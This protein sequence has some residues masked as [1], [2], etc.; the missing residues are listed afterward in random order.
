MST[1]HNAKPVDNT[2]VVTTIRLSRAAHDRL[3]EIAQA[4]HRSVTQ[5]VRRLV[6]LRIAEYPP[7]EN[8]A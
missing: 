1:K 7:L 4:E 5:E 3:R 6:D 2:E 8:V